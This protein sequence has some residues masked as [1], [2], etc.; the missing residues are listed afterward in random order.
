MIVDFLTL[1]QVGG[2]AFDGISMSAAPAAH[3]ISH[4]AVFVVLVV[5]NV[6]GEDHDAGAHLFLAFLQHAGQR[7]LSRA[8]GV[9]AAI[10]LFFGRSW[11]KADGAAR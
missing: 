10:L 8:G 1:E 5:V 9:S 6:P 11:C 2:L 4:A 3:K 7:L